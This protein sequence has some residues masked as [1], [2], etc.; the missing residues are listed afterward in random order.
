MRDSISA[1]EQTALFSD[2]D[3]TE[4]TVVNCLNLIP[5]DTIT[6]LADNVLSKNTAACLTL[7]FELQEQGRDLGILFNMM[8][9]ALFLQ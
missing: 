7:L 3:I 5:H 8:C 1:L 6:E 9:E 2:N 4:D